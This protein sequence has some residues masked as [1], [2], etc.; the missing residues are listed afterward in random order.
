M[1]YRRQ[2]RRRRPHRYQASNQSGYLG[3]ASRA[4]AVAYGVK[5]LLNIEYKSIRVTLPTAPTNTPVITPVSA[6]AQGDDFDDRQGRK[7]KLFSYR[8][9]GRVTVNASATGSFYRVVILRDNNGSTTRPVITDVY[10]D[11][12]AFNGG[13]MPLDDPQ[14]NARFSILSD[15]LYPL[16]ISGVNI[17][18]INIYKKLS[19]HVYFTGT[20]ANDE[21][22]GML[23]MITS[24]NEATNTPSVLVDIVTKFIDN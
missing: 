2:Y 9:K 16:S 13:I 10:P 6:P 12:A 5:K 21:G 4:L 17:R 3:T 24:S 15:N 19:S 14:T 18:P 1:P 11:A 23:Y 7:I 22:K 8:L 20:G